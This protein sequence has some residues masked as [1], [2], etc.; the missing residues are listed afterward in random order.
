MSIMGGTPLRILLLMVA[1]SMVVAHESGHILITRLL[2]GRFHRVVFRG[3]AIGVQLTVDGL[4]PQSVAWTLLAGP[5][6]EALVFGAAVA[7]DLQNAQWWALLLFTQWIVNLV[8]W[9][10]CRMTAPGSGNSGNSVDGPLCLLNHKDTERFCLPDFPNRGRHCIRCSP[11]RP[12]S[13]IQ[14]G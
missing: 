13:E 11:C 8:P 4:S 3:W 6:A 10:W 7:T 1:V 12:A 2:G 9:G 14:S 5:L